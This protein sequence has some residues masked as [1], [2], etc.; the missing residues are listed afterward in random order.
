[1]WVRYHWA[2][3]LILKLSD[4]MDILL[5]AFITIYILIQ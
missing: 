2:V 4:N 5:E 3:L 1:M